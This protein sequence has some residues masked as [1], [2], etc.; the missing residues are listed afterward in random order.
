MVPIINRLVLGFC[1]EADEWTGDFVFLST[2]R[3]VE[4]VIVAVMLRMQHFV[5][6]RK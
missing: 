5:T 3:R 1:R 6:Y 2:V 4:F